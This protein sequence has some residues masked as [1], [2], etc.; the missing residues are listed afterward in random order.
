[1]NLSTKKP[2][3]VHDFTLCSL[4]PKYS[5]VYCTTSFTHSSKLEQHK[6][7]LLENSVQC[8][9]FRA[10]QSCIMIQH[11]ITNSSLLGRI[12]MLYETSLD[13][14]SSQK[15]TMRRERCRLRRQQQSVSSSLFPILSYSIWCMENPMN[16]RSHTHSWLSATIGVDLP[17]TDRCDIWHAHTHKHRHTFFHSFPAWHT[18]NS[19]CVHSS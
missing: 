8:T 5:P 1:M 14:W 13:L 2:N 11:I 17:Q 19:C 7:M 3:W 10:S 16:P 15:T 18:S 4:H 6:L 9:Y 12:L